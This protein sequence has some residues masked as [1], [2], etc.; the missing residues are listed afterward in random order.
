MKLVLGTAQLGTDYGIQN[1]GKPS[2]ENAKKLLDAAVGCGIN[3]F[4]TAADY[5]NA[6]AIV[7]DYLEYRGL[8]NSTQVITK[9]SPNILNT[10]PVNQYEDVLQYQI[11]H[12]MH[13]LKIDRLEGAL[14]HKAESVF[15]PDAIKA[16]IHMKHLGIVNKVGVS[17]YTPEQANKALYYDG[18]D[19]IQVPYNVLDR[20]LD[21]SDFF[22]KAQN[23]GITVLARS[24]LLQ[25]L[26]TMP[27]EKLPIHMDFAK[28]YVMQFQA[29]CKELSVSPLECAVGFVAAHP[30][31]DYLV[32]GSDGVKQLQEYVCAAKKKMP[33]NKYNVLLSKFK[34]VPE[35][36]V[37]PNLWG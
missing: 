21:R 2:S 36:V 37:M 29:L 33:L 23:K 10:I 20:R 32:F 24:S 34:G 17:I 4:D 19:I 12:S 3:I 14:F 1:H 8:Q 28:I 35:R 26:L 6:E 16:L 22:E 18:L 7:G 13:Q 5:G 27:I 9:L 25:G 31:I 11:E 30:Y 15:H